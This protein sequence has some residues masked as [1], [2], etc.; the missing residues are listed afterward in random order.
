MCSYKEIKTQVMNLHSIGTT[1]ISIASII[2][3]R[4]KFM[5]TESEVKGII[6]SFKKD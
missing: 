1:P 6:Q 3:L 5:F 2:S 4:E